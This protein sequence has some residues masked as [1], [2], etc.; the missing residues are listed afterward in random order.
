M[1]HDRFSALPPAA[2]LAAAGAIG[3]GHWALFF[4]DG[5]H[6]SSP[7]AAV[8]ASAALASVTG[9]LAGSLRPGAWWSLATAGCW[10]APAWGAVTLA[11]GSPAGAAILL[12]PL[13]AALA[14]SRAGARRSRRRDGPAGT[15]P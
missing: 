14:A 1:R 5:L 4:G 11:M 15:A 8:A 2:L 9:F 12:L 13:A 6:G 3:L 7:W 10:G